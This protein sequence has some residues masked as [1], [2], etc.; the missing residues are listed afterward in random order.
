MC[1]LDGNQIKVNTGQLFGTNE[2]SAAQVCFVVQKQHLPGTQLI[3]GGQTYCCVVKT[4][5]LFSTK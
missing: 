5:H 2:I 4:V 1:G 3:F